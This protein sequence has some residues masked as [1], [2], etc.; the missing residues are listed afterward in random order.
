MDEQGRL[1]VY[2]RVDA[3]TQ[4]VRDA[5]VELGASLERESDE[6][7]IVQASVPIQALEALAAFPFVRAVTPPSYGQVN[8]GS[9]LTEGDGLLSFAALR[10]AQ[11]IDGIGV[12]VGVISDSIAG[13]A[14]AIAAGDLPATTFNRN[15]ANTLTSTTGGVI[16][17][18][19]R[20]D[21]DLE[22]GLGSAATGAE[23][24]AMLEIVHDI[25]PGAQ[26][27]FANFRTGLEFIAAVDFLASV[28]DVVV[29]DDLTPKK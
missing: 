23:G 15:G 25:A 10:A 29:D 13:L 4:G 28:S 14:T 12:T 3:I 9:K 2:V 6:Q 27:R 7:G 5:L 17:T 8:V 26:L 20:A 21:G 16:A 11:G 18:S 24:T 19:F 22:G 1:Q